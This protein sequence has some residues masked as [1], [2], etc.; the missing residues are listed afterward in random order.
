MKRN[1]SGNG[2]QIRVLEREWSANGALGAG[3]ERGADDAPSKGIAISQLLGNRTRLNKGMQA[4]AHSSR[5]WCPSLCFKEYNKKS[6][7]S[8]D[9]LK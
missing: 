4:D 8:I 6:S 5:H 7:N 1:W 3:M 9:E 2:A